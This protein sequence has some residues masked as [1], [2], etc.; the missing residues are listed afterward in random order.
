MSEA[1][2]STRQAKK[3]YLHPAPPAGTCY[4]GDVASILRSK[5][6]GPYEIT[7]DVMFPDDETYE[8]VKQ[9]G[10]L[11]GAAVA[12]LY[13]IDERDVIAALWFAPARAFKATFPRFRAS[14]G[15]DETDTH[16][17]QQHAPLLYLSL[18]WGRQGTEGGRS[19]SRL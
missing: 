8:K 9:S 1:K 3:Y 2:S 18:P 13:G 12:K 4:L 17:S 10:R 7:F 11:T 14:A 16:G 6:A 5:I 15:F 19:N